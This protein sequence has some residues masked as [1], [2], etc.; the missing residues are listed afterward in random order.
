MS[1]ETTWWEVCDSSSIVEGSRKHACIEGRYVTVFRNR[2]KL[3]VIDSV[4]HHAGGP[5]TLGSIEDIEEIGLTVV[6]CPWH[7]FMISING[8][9]DGNEG[10]LK[11]YKGVDIVDGKP[12]PSGWKV[13]KIVQRPHFVK[14]LDGCVYVSLN[15]NVDLQCVSDVDA[16]NVHCGSQFDAQVV[17]EK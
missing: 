12:K 10:G 7:K 15:E 14:E 1:I 2:G 4:C 11:V 17:N 13:G 9:E 3:S 16:K 5:L 6:L 8:G